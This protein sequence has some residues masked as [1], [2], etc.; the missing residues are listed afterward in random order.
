MKLPASAI[1]C[2]EMWRLGF[3]ATVTPGGRPSVSPKGT[4]IVVDES[5]IA[6]GEIRSPQTVANLTANPECE[7][8]IVDQFIR[9]GVRIRGRAA[10]L[11][12]GTGEFGALIPRFEDIWGDLAGRINMIVLVPVDEVKPLSTPPYDDGVTEE[13]MIALYK[14]KFAEMYP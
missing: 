2:I 8:N 6:F 9:K 1:R 3:V 14:A 11:Q 13:E 4:F 5:T 10:F 7:V 12:R